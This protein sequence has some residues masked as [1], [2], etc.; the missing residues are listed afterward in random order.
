MKGL[1]SR[2]NPDIQHLNRKVSSI[3]PEMV[4]QRRGSHPY[5]YQPQ[6]VKLVVKVYED[7]VLCSRWPLLK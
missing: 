4:C 3:T 7:Y 1:E 2:L 6:N 5:L